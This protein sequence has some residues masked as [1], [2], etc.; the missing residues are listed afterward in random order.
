MH[1][2]DTTSFAIDT[3]LFKCRELFL[4]NFPPNT[5]DGSLEWGALA[6]IF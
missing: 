5:H 1:N 4:V 6:M 3:T 2:T